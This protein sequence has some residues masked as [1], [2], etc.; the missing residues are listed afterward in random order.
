[1]LVGMADSALAGLH[2]VA[3]S[4]KDLDASIAWYVDVLGLTEVI[5]LEAEDRRWVILR[6][7]ATRQEVGLVEHKAPGE[8][9]APQNLGLD[10]A[11]F[12]VAS[13]EEMEA[14]AASFQQRGIESSGVVA[15]P[16]GAMLHFKDPDGIALALFWHR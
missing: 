16:F 5:R 12:S 11:A 8:A 13:G 3:L 14:W 10:H 6:L 4:V 2:H 1:M 15:T 7:P 9:F